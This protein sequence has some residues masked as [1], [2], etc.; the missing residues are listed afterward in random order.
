MSRMIDDPFAD[1]QSL[2]QRYAARGARDERGVLS[3]A[4][5]EVRTLLTTST[6]D[7]AAVGVWTSAGEP[8]TPVA[9][10]CSSPVAVPLAHKAGSGAAS[11]L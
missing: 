10:R 1:E 3:I 9:R 5:A 7:T 8:D 6:S 2:G 4:G 11:M